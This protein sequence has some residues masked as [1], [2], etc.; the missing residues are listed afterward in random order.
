MKR[1]Y[2]IDE[3]V[4]HEIILVSA[5]AH[6]QRHRNLCF[7]FLL[8]GLMLLVQPV[9]ACIMAGKLYL[10]AALFWVLS[11]VSFVIWSATCKKYPLEYFK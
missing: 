3:S 10:S 5:E 11:G 1:W 8:L 4:I 7:V 9:I 2:S 6:Y